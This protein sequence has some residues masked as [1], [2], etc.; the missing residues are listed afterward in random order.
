[1]AIHQARFLR[2][3][4]DRKLCKASDR[5]ILA[6]MGD[7]E[8]GEPEAED[9]IGLAAREKLNNLI[10]VIS[11]NL[12]RLGEPVRGNSKIMQELEAKFRDAGWNVI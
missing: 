10:F 6:F 1:M 11:C 5:K 12:Q 4:E 3:S 2:Y 7:G 9:A 8:M